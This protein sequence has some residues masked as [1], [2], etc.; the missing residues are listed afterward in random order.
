M[1]I[2]IPKFF[3]QKMRPNL[4]FEQTAVYLILSVQNRR[5]NIAFFGIDLRGQL[6]LHSLICSTLALRSIWTFGTSGQTL[7]HVGWTA[8][9]LCWGFG[10][11]ITH[12]CFIQVSSS[13]SSCSFYRLILW[14]SSTFLMSLRLGRDML[15]QIR[16][17]LQLPKL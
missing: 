9:T 16:T 12:F 5:P 15:D 7:L 1:R 10:D 8:D 11:R 3:L 6:P 13:P 4:S 17:I 2:S 14:C